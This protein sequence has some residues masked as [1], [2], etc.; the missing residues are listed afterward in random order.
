MD[1]L[2][3]IEVLDGEGYHLP[4]WLVYVQRCNDLQGVKKNVPF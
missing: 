4:C 3:V 2:Q 1:G